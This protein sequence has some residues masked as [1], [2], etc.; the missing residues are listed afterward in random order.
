MSGGVIRELVTL[1]G[2]DIDQ[3][4][5][6][7]LDTGINLI[8]S[9]LAGIGIAVGIASAGVGYL[10]N[11]AG[12]DEQTRIAFETMLG[13]AEEAKIR[14]EELKQFA[15]TTPFEL[16]GLKDAA[17]RLLAFNI[18]GQE[19]I[20]T[21]R[22]LGDISAGVGMDK[23]PQLIL[24]FGQVKAATRLTG[25]ELRQ[26]TEAGVPLLGELAKTMGKSEAQIQELIHSKKISFE[27][28]R[29]A[30]F[31]L[32]Q[33]GGRF[34]NLMVKQSKSFLGMI[35][36]FKD[37]I[38]IVAIEVGNELLPV[39]KE[40]L[41][42]LIDWAQ[43]NKEI[44]KSELLK[45]ART[46]VD[47]IFGMINVLKAFKDVLSGIVHLFG[48]WND[49]IS[50]VAKS[51]TVILG[52]GLLYGIGLLAQG[53]W[54]LTVAWKAMG[55]AALWAQAKAMLIPL[56]IGAIIAAIALIAE[57][58]Y[59]FTQGRDSVFGRF[60][61][62]MGVAFDYLS[63]KFSGLG[64]FMKAIIAG[65]L[66]PIRLLVLSFRSI[67]VMID[68]IRGK[69]GFLDGVKEIGKITLADPTQSFGA[70]LGLGENL[71]Q[72]SNY[73]AGNN[74]PMVGLGG[75]AKE[76]TVPGAG[77]VSAENT[78]NLNVTGME[79]K[80]AEDLVMGSL[81]DTLGTMMRNAVR[82]GGSQVER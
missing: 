50:L 73:M 70:A 44:V 22:A 77:V 31:S 47:L 71:N 65:I 14:L 63:E 56:A 9:S 38:N 76:N 26:F 42:S 64:G 54:G 18:Q 67:G 1:W 21:L 33:D 66:A 62:G 82:D 34:A 5:L 41:G 24:A 53:L 78:I 57:D 27:Q 29:T 36:N 61:K 19:I 60:V 55:T 6:K 51:L 11:E 74:T 72:A 17:K 49:A 12:Q 75:S 39:A 32:S 35:S 10:L 20:P 16:P 40:L 8:K 59:A 79:P 52:A 13:S 43:A 2:F 58:I 30:L 28:T 7:E 68:M 45:F 4:P 48:D 37:Y 15:A 23:L 46:L 69:K 80:A 25:M 3:K 81:N